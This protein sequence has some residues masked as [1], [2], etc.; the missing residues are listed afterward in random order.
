M[1]TIV[2]VLSATIAIHTNN[3]VVCLIFGTI[4]LYVLYRTIKEN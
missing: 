1:K 3:L 2:G 4:S